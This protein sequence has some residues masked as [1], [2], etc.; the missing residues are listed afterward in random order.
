MLPRIEYSVVVPV[1]PENAFRAFCDLSR[2]LDRGIYEEA[3][4]VAGEP[5]QVGSRIRY[6][7][8]KPVEATIS[9]VVISCEPPRSVNVLNHALGVTAEQQVTFTSMPRAGTRV[10]MSMEF[11]GQSSELPDK[12]VRQTIAFFTK[13]ALDTM[14]AICHPKRAASSR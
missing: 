1:A 6:V 11:V 5:W 8:V 12:E 9:A 10:R 4:W 13:D 7:V 2:L 3:S 14:A